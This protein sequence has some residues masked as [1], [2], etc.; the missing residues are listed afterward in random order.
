[1]F[2][3]FVNNRKVPYD[4]DGITTVE[5]I[6]RG[7]LVQAASAGILQKDSIEVTVPKYKDI[8]Q[9]DRANRLLPDIKF[10]AL[11][12]GAIHKTKIDGTISV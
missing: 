4:D 3:A 8:P 12:Q 9:A 7:V 5:G 11:Y 1:M 2:S 10:T 6:V